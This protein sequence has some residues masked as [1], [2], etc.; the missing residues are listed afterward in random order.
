MSKLEVREIGPISGETEVRLADGATAVGFGGVSNI[1]KSYR[2][3][4]FPLTNGVWT[5]VLHNVNSIPNLSF[6]SDTGVFTVGAGDGGLYYINWNCSFSSTKDENGLRSA[7]SSIFV[8]GSEKARALSDMQQVGPSIIATPVSTIHPL[9]E[10]DE[11]TIYAFTEGHSSGDGDVVLGQP[12]N[13]VSSWTMFRIG[14]G[15]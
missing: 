15:L 2:N 1:H 13:S 6:S 5:R 8:N 11:V 14:D 9:N 7:F 10:G 12:G 3:S 4:D